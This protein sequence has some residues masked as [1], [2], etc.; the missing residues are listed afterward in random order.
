MYRHWFS[1]AI[2]GILLALGL[3]IA[4][5]S[6][7]S[8]ILLHDQ[9]QRSASSKAELSIR[10]LVHDTYNKSLSSASD[11][12]VSPVVGEGSHLGIIEEVRV[13]VSTAQSVAKS[14]LAELELETQTTSTLHRDETNDKNLASLLLPTDRDCIRVQLPVPNPRPE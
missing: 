3:S 8:D 10:P 11:S 1:S 4:S 14:E 9:R 2:T 13:A 7:S 5:A 12:G 6:S